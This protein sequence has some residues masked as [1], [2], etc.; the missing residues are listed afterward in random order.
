M[1]AFHRIALATGLLGIMMVAGCDQGSNETGAG[2]M[3]K[4]NV[5]NAPTSASGYE[6]YMKKQM[7]NNPVGAGSNYEAQKKEGGGQAPAETPKADAP[8]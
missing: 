8:K 3:S 7:Q 2:D 6:D 5:G 4:T 1:K